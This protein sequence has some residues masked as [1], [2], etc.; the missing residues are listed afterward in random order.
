M[1]YTGLLSLTA[2]RGWCKGDMVDEGAKDGW[3]E[4]KRGGLEGLSG[5]I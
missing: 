2:S 4:V 1:D 3:N 5:L